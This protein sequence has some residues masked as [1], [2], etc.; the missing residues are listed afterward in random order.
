MEDLSAADWLVGA[1]VGWQRLV[2]FGPAGFEDYGRLRFVPDPD[3]PGLSEADVVILEDHPSDVDQ[4]R[5]VL[6]ALAAHT[7][8]AAPYYYCVWDGYA[9]SFPDPELF[10]GPLVPLP[11]RKYALFAGD[12][13]GIER[14]EEELGGGMACPP[15]AFVWPADRRWCFTND[16][17][18]H[19]AGIG[20]SVGAVEALI[21]RT[22]VDV[23][24]ASPDRFPLG[25]DS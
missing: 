13:D 7:G 6:R 5:T 8:T 2:T 15:P 25:Y 1:D 10:R 12:L 9:G 18:P 11:H 14:W 24:R 19:W 20:G 16:V 4:T 21:A 17:D 23:V 22:D 3:A